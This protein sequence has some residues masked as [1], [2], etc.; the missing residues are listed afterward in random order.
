MQDTIELSKMAID[1]QTAI[2]ILLSVCAAH[3]GDFAKGFAI[4]SEIVLGGIR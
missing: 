4:A 3:A 1:H 2:R